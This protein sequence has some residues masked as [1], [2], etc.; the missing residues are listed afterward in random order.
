MMN[1]Y[2]VSFY[3]H[4]VIVKANVDADD[5]DTAKL[6]AI[7]AIKNQTGLDVSSVLDLNVEMVR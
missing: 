4:S 6:V 3:Y 5:E 2:Q 7:D 1:R